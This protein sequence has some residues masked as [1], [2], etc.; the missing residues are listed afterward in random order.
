M[1]N[2][3][4]GLFH[5][6]CDPSD[7]SILITGTGSEGESPPKGAPDRNKHLTELSTLPHSF[8]EIKRN[9]VSRDEIVARVQLIKDTKYRCNEYLQ[10]CKIHFSSMLEM[11]SGEILVYTNRQCNR[12]VPA[13]TEPQD[14]Q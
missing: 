11:K 3:C 14:F 10:Y 9:V 8:L 2:L 4:L 12:V 5:N 7:T 13:R 1:R 6:L